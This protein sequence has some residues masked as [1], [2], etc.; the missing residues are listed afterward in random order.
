MTCFEFVGID[1]GD[2]GWRVSGDSGVGEDHVE[3]AES[4]HGL[5]DGFGEGA[6]V[7]HIDGQG[8]GSGVTER[9]GDLIDDVLCE[10]GEHDVGAAGVQCCGAGCSDAAGGA[11]DEDGLTVEV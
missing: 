6:A 9:F 4:V 8:Q 1:G 7:G 3:A 5:C 2:R 11:G 10:I